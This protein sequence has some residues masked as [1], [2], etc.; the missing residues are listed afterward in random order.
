M[1][2]F[3]SRF[4]A[5]NSMKHTLS[6]P[7]LAALP[8]FMYGN[9]SAPPPEG[10]YNLTFGPSHHFACLVLEPVIDIVMHLQSKAEYWRVPNGIMDACDFEGSP[11]A[12]FGS[13]HGNSVSL[14]L[15]ALVRFRLERAA[16]VLQAIE[17]GDGH[18]QANEDMSLISSSSSWTLTRLT[19]DELTP[20][21]IG[22][23]RRLD[24]MRVANPDARS[25]WRALQP[26]VLSVL[27]P[28]IVLFS[29][30]GLGP[31]KRAKLRQ[32][33][34]ACG[35]SRPSRPKREPIRS[36]HHAPIATPRHATTTSLCLSS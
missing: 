18:E 8:L 20:Q 27:N 35:K 25:V 22:K 36:T 15:R 23:R 31:M 16:D 3:R 14:L 6:S 12:W 4:R 33:L 32:E 21:V 10:G 34:A 2:F 24:L 29:H 9:W 30:D 13:F 28:A 11:C 1:R 26:A 19:L 7:S 17:V 5:P